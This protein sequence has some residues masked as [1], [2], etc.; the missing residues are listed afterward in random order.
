MTIVDQVTATNQVR[1]CEPG[2]FQYHKSLKN[3]VSWFF[4]LAGDYWG[5]CLDVACLGSRCTFLSWRLYASDRR[6][7]QASKAIRLR[8][9]YSAAL[10]VD[11]RLNIIKKPKQNDAKISQ[12]L[13]RPSVELRSN[14][15]FNHFILAT[16]YLFFQGCI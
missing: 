8:S 5:C 6:T 13:V 7:N 15:Y 11:W 10:W 4:F 9:K 16:E 3:Q 14:S 2:V 12:Y 1:V